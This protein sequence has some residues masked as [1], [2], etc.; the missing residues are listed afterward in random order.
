MIQTDAAT[1]PIGARVS[2]RL[3]NSTGR[4]VTCDLCASRLEQLGD[5]GPWREIRESLQEGCVSRWVTLAPGQATDGA[6][7]AGSH[8]PAGRFRLRAMLVE[9]RGSPQH[10]VIS[11]IFTLTP[12]DN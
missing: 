12:Q 11:N 10:E 1:Y 5:D 4:T 9:P 6:F 8:V 2:I 3:V 7:T